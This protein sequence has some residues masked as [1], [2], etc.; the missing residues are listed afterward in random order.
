[1]AQGAGKSLGGAGGGR[2]RVYTCDMGRVETWSIL[3][4]PGQ[5]S[6]MSDIGVLELDSLQTAR[7]CLGPDGLH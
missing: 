5:Q 4:Q 7:P 1:M 3:R 6:L 2:V